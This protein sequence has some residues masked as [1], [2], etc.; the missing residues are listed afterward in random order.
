MEMEMEMIDDFAMKLCFTVF[1]VMIVFWISFS[2]SGVY[3]SLGDIAREIK[4]ITAEIER[5]KKE[6]KDK[7][8]EN[9]NE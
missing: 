6:N 4:K 1:F 3:S 7:N 9:S 8:K 2:F 5:I